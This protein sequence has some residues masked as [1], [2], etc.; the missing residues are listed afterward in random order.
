MADQSVPT[1]TIV[2]D[3]RGGNDVHVD[4]ISIVVDESK[5]DLSRLSL[6][7][8]T[9]PPAWYA[10]VTFPV[11]SITV[12]V[13][14]GRIFTGYVTSWTQAKPSGSW[15]I[16]AMDVLY[17]AE[18]EWLVPDEMTAMLTFSGQVTDFVRGLL[19]DTC[20]YATVSV[21]NVPYTLGP[22]EPFEY[23]FESVKGL[24]DRINGILQTE[25][26]A[27]QNGGVHWD[28]ATDCADSNFGTTCPAVEGATRGG[29]YFRNRNRGSVF[30][31]ISNNCP[32]YSVAMNAAYAT[33]NASSLLLCE[34]R[35]HK[36]PGELATHPTRGNLLSWSQ[37]EDEDT[38]RVGAIVF[39]LPPIREEYDKGLFPYLPLA[40]L[41]NVAIVSSAIIQERWI[42]AD[43]A[44][45]LAEQS[46]VKR[47]TQWEAIGNVLFHVNV[48]HFLDTDAYFGYGK[49]MSVTHT[50]NDAGYTIRGESNINYCAVKAGVVSAIVQFQEHILSADVGGGVERYEGAWTLDAVYNATTGTWD[51][52]SGF[53]Y[54]Y[55]WEDISLPSWTNDM[56]EVAFVHA[57]GVF[58]AG[59]LGLVPLDGYALAINNQG[60]WRNGAVSDWIRTPAEIGAEWVLV[61]TAAEWAAAASAGYD[62]GVVTCIE[63]SGSNSRWPNRAFTPAMTHFMIHEP[64]FML[65]S[66]IIRFGVLASGSEY[67]AGVVGGWIGSSHIFLFTA[68]LAMGNL[69]NLQ[70]IG[71]VHSTGGAYAPWAGW[72]NWAGWSYNDV[73]GKA[74]I[75]ARPLNYAFG[76]VCYSLDASAAVVDAALPSHGGNWHDSPQRFNHLVDARWGVCAT[77]GNS[78]RGTVAYRIVEGGGVAAIDVPNVGGGGLLDWRG[79]ALWGGVELGDMMAMM[80]SAPDSELGRWMEKWGG[81]GGSGV[82]FIIAWTQP[83]LFLIWLVSTDGR[84][85]SM[86]RYYDQPR[87]PGDYKTPEKALWEVI[88]ADL[89]T[90]VLD[91]TWD[92]EQDWGGTNYSVECPYLINPYSAGFYADG[93][94]FFPASLAGGT[95]YATGKRGDNI[96]N[97]APCGKPIRRVITVD[98]DGNEIDELEDCPPCS[99]KAEDTQCC[100]TTPLYAA[101]GSKVTAVAGEVSVRF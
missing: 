17:V 21:G 25:L 42:A 35:Q 26:W 37:V 62:A 95:P 91:G 57:P 36:L 31:D 98:E 82:P 79:I 63:E 7:T 5:G 90:I 11:N 14:S 65:A 56:H 89:G 60:I 34:H 93:Q 38:Y 51:D 52:A 84:L 71:A 22:E 33:Y 55:K 24:L 4:A 6:E 32:A 13:L 12:N 47:T 78:V 43:V 45:N 100:G 30:V 39:G 46:I 66:G 61:M 41:N 53:T 92:L 59:G 70:C 16:E 19:T 74:L 28:W 18:N 50:V 87:A 94:R 97:F 86:S 77:A 8:L 96:Y 64:H 73:N 44:R 72:W 49:V 48:T 29:I 54:A 15:T 88:W 69:T 68:T 101:D 1:L 40:N 83:Y 9:A 20:G 80:G 75:W 76:A 10:D 58:T 3:L 23:G 85:Y 67:Y 27:D 99:K 2:T 81:G